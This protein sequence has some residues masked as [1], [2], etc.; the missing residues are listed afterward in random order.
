MAQSPPLPHAHQTRHQPHNNS[1]VK[2]VEADDEAVYSVASSSTAAPP[3][4]AGMAPVSSYGASVKGAKGGPSSAGSITGPHIA[5]SPTSSIWTSS[6][7]TPNSSALLDARSCPRQKCFSSSNVIHC[8]ISSY[9][10]LG[11]LKTLYPPWRKQSL[12]FHSESQARRQISIFLKKRSVGRGEQGG[13]VRPLKASV[14]QVTGACP[15]PCPHHS[16][17]QLWAATI[18]V[19]VAGRHSQVGGLPGWVMRK[20]SHGGGSTGNSRWL[21]Y[22]NRSMGRGLL[23]FHKNIKGGLR[24]HRSGYR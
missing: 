6:G 21:R 18:W 9:H 13:K 4:C 24:G 14:I 8:G 15:P 2:P 19:P 5:R 11:S 16:P 3:S 1:Q 22:H 7:G 20:S 17:I 12:D 10:S 23:R